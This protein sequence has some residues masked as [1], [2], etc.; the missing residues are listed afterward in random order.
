I[1]MARDVA[2]RFN[3]LY[4]AGRESFVSPEAEI[5]DS[6]ATLPGSDG[7]KMSKSYD[8]T[9]PSFEGGAKGS[10]DAIAR[11]VTDSRSPGEPK[12]P[13]SAHLVT[14]HDAFADAATREAFRRDS[15]AG[16]GWGDAKQRVVDSIE[17]HVGPMRAAYAE[18]MAHPE[19]I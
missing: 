4:G 15:V 16:S 14:S 7:R 9:V 3:H 6:V 17:A 12:D 18:S 8:N 11:V 10:K 5:E 19:R 13:D 2:Q 1:E